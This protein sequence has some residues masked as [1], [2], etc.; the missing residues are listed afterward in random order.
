MENEN[1]SRHTDAAKDYELDFVMEMI[2]NSIMNEWQGIVYQDTPRRYQE[3]LRN[4]G[5]AVSSSG[6]KQITDQVQRDNMIQ[7]LDKNSDLWK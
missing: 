2:D 3:W 7:Y 6:V 4:K 1:N 5:S